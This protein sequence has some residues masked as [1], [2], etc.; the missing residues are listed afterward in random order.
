MILINDINNSKYV[1]MYIRCTK[2]VTLCNLHLILDKLNA[3]SKLTWK[4][5]NS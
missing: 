5:H 1:Y 3:R 2:D 4:I